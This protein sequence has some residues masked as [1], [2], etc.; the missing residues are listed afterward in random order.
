MRKMSDRA[1]LKKIV[2]KNFNSFQNEEIVFDPGF[3]VITGPNG[4]G[5]S[6]IFQA[7]KFALGSNE[8]DGRSS[9]WSDFIRIGEKFGSVELSIENGSDVYRIKRTLEKE[10]APGFQIAL[11]NEKMHNTTAKRVQR[12]VGNLGY[13]PDNIFA[14]VSQGNITDLKKMNPDEVC[15]F[16][17]LGLGLTD[18]RQRIMDRKKQIAELGM[19]IESLETIRD[20]ASYE[21]ELLKPKIKRFKEKQVLEKEKANLEKEKKWLNRK[22]IKNEIEE[23]ESHINTMGE[24]QDKMDVKRSKFVK[25]LEKASEKTYKIET[26][27]ADNEKEIVRLKTSKKNDETRV[28]EWESGKDSIADEISKIDSN[29]KVLNAALEQ[30]LKEKKLV[31]ETVKKYQFELSIVNTQ[32]AD[33]MRKFEKHQKLREKNQKIAEEYNEVKKQSDLIEQKIDTHNER[34][35]TI[36][37]QIQEKM[38][39][40]KIL[41][42]ELN[43]NKWFIEDPEKNTKKKL[44][45][46]KQ[47]LEK[48]FKKLN[49]QIGDLEHENQRLEKNAEHLKDS[50]LM[51]EMPKRPEMNNLMAEIQARNLNVVGPLIDIIDFDPIIGPAVDAILNKYTLKSFVAFN[52]NDFLLMDE[53]IKKHKAK[54]NVFQPLN[55]TKITENYHIRPNKERGILG[56]LVNLIHPTIHQKSIRRILISLCRNTLLVKDKF[57]GYEIIKSGMHHGNVVTLSGNI[58]KKHKYAL[59]SQASRGT[60]Q[61]KTPAEQRR[62]ILQIQSKLK[63]NRRELKELKD[64]R[65]VLQN[66]LNRVFQRLSNVDLLSYN[67]HKKNIAISNKKQ[68]LASKKATVEEKNVLTEELAQ[69]ENELAKLQKK[70]P[71]NYQES[72]EFMST[73]YSNMEDLEERAKRINQNLNESVKQSSTLENSNKSLKEKIETNAAKRTEFKQKL[74][75][76]DLELFKLM[77][78][79]NEYLEQIS[80]LEKKN[81]KNAEELEKLRLEKSELESIMNELDQ[82]ISKIKIKI[83]TSYSELYQKKNTLKEIQ[84]DIS[85][86]GRSYKER[87]FT[88]VENELNVVY[89]KLREYYDVSAQ[90]L[91][92]KKLLETKI[93]RIAEKK[94]EISNEIIEAKKAENRLEDE[95][96]KKFE[97][98]LTI[99]EDKINERFQKVGIK[100][101]G[102]LT[103]EGD[104]E[105]LE[106]EIYV[107]FNQGEERR[108]SVLSGGEQTLFAISLMLTLQSL[109]PSPMCIFDECQMF[110]DV[111]NSHEVSKLIKNAAKQGIQFIIIAPD[112]SKTIVQEADSI[113]GV[114]KTGE[115][116]V[117]TVVDYPLDHFQ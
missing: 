102:R 9:R 60:K 107:R 8:R 63:R 64:K 38:D 1:I 22:K 37:E 59:E 66:E 41:S 72:S 91:E 30:N 11:D 80:A 18:L 99:I 78:Q 56:Y 36:A 68:L 53:L 43:K 57:I 27:V 81:E 28:N 67:F 55:E 51:K 116:D 33:L 86:L 7:I 3:T 69:I 25:D 74:K 62:K 12:T 32:K 29:L 109:N 48:G 15:R 89:E 16:L 2:L 83:E 70:L 39:Q 26:N 88:Q 93:Q 44:E 4:A 98:K 95:F 111:E 92:K 61:Y 96:R 112:A 65:E 19:Q 100:K 106:T 31:D 13:N 46:K 71:K 54:C 113:L 40:I 10:S 73:F 75:E 104:L 49:M 47:R 50:V 77:E 115:S 34:L 23:L 24:K 79:I 58:L 17:E 5:K 52:K 42:K 87:P 90:I 85:E 14:F 114:A 35:N 20:S 108:L 84:I 94:H 82:E 97:E 6:S 117:S 103:L 105:N 76:S 110:L 45:R 101:S 21:L